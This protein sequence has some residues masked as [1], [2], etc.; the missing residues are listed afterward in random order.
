MVHS[1]FLQ[2]ASMK[3]SVLRTLHRFS[4][5]STMRYS[6]FPRRQKLLR[7]KLWDISLCFA[8]PTGADCTDKR[9]KAVSARHLS[10]LSGQP[11]DP[12]WRWRW[13]TSD[14]EL[15]SKSGQVKVGGCGLCVPLPEACNQV[16]ERWQMNWF[17]SACSVWYEQVT[18]FFFVFFY[19]D[20]LKSKRQGCSQVDWLWACERISSAA[21]CTSPQR[22][23]STNCLAVETGSLAPTTKISN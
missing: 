3:S 23:C 13:V 16:A 20:G 8:F 19:M 17:W 7:L 9:R 14:V 15:I 4:P 11:L 18:S 10:V 2:T 1:V 21:P 5:K 22:R 6:L 12:P